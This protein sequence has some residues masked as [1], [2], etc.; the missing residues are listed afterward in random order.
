MVGGGQWPVKRGKDSAEDAQ[1]R[2]MLMGQIPEM[3]R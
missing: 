1:K 3:R 2:K